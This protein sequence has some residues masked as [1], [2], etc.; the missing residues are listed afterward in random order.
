MS[1]TLPT[2]SRFWLDRPTS[3][4]CF[5]NVSL[6]LA[7]LIFYQPMVEFSGH[8]DTFIFSTNSHCWSDPPT[9]G[10]GIH[11]PSLDMTFVIFYQPL[12]QFSGYSNYLL[13]TSSHERHVRAYPLFPLS[14]AFF[15]TTSQVVRCTF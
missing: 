11:K 14:Y 7:S 5:H 1:W 3:R 13:W 2:S 6:D 4:V 12:V 15:G 9:S 10:G 8:S